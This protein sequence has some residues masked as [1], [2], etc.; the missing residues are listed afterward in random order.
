MGQT[1]M[2]K[3]DAAAAAW[4][5]SKMPSDPSEIIR[6]RVTLDDAPR[7]YDV[8][9]NQ[10]EHCTKIVLYPPGA[11]RMASYLT[12]HWCPMLLGRF[13]RGRGA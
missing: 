11:D 9:C 2:I 10:Q 6:H 13:A 3:Y 1:Q 12:I 8:F 4:G 5:A 7:I